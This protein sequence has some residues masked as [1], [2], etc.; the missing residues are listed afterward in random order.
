VLDGLWE[1][2]RHADAVA[3]LALDAEGRV[4]GVTQTRPAIGATTWELPAGLVD[5]GESPRAAAARELA[6]EAKLGGRLDEVIRLYASPGFT[7]ELVYLF[8]ASDLSAAEAPT[9]DPHEDVRVEWRDPLAA[10]HDAA[11]GRLATSGVTLLGLRH[12]LARLGIDPTSRAA[13]E[14]DRSRADGA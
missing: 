14:T 3:V 12:A 13:T 6:E 11:A 1:V 8:E 5:P 2:V 9:S 7:D 4:L 10:W